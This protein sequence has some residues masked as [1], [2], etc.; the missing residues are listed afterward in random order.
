M[1]TF[2][3]AI[4]DSAFNEEWD[5]EKTPLDCIVGD[6]LN[7]E[8]KETKLK[9]TKLKDIKIS[10]PVFKKCLDDLKNK[11]FKETEIVQEFLKLKK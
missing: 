9:E 2:K 3:W 10:D 5:Y 1:K 8:N 4:E 7:S 6:D 11:G